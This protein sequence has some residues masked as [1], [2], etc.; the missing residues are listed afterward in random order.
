MI[1]IT[2]PGFLVSFSFST[3]RRRRRRCRRRCLQLL[4]TRLPRHRATRLRAAA[5]LQPVSFFLHAFA[6][7]R[8]SSL[9]LVLLLWLQMMMM[10]M[11]LTLMMMLPLPPLTMPTETQYQS[12]LWRVV[13]WTTAAAATPRFYPQLHA[14]LSIAVQPPRRGC[15]CSYIVP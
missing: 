9:V 5:V 15:G 6:P 8:P 13:R 14:A 2:R 7:L 4:P 3:C 11:M 10:M 1:Y 12:V